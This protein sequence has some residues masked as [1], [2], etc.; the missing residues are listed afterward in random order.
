MQ[1]TVESNFVTYI[2]LLPLLRQFYQDGNIGLHTWLGWG[3]ETY[4]DCL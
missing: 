2:L 3:N 4:T 1:S